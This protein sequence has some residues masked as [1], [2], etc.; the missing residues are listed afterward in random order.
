[1][2]LPSAKLFSAFQRNSSQADPHKHSPR[3]L[4]SELDRLSSQQ[5]RRDT[6][7][8]PASLQP[9]RLWVT[10]SLLVHLAFSSQQYNVK[11]F[12]TRTESPESHPMPSQPAFFSLPHSLA[13]TPTSSPYTVHFLFS[14]FS[15]NHFLSQLCKGSFILYLTA[16]STLG[17]I[18][19]SFSILVF[20]T[21]RS[22]YLETFFF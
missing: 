7:T 11:C 19:Q 5:L 15:T 21:L 12:N 18:S 22:M 10:K 13:Y 8:P 16:K 6:K 3:S 20:G 9:Q 17:Q 1:M 2:S 14:L 4:Q